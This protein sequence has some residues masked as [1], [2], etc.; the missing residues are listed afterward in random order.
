ADLYAR[1]RERGDRRDEE[2]EAEAEE[3]EAA[4]PE[5]DAGEQVHRVKSP[6]G[7]ARVAKCRGNGPGTTAVSAA[8]SPF[9]MQVASRRAIQRSYIVVC[10]LCRPSSIRNG[11][12]GLRSSRRRK[13]SPTGRTPCGCT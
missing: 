12:R 3:T 9:A 4:E 13:C 10:R 7:R 8:S 2:G 5:R 1:R 6:G 11:V